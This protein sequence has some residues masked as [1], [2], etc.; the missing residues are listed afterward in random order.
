MSLSL[1]PLPRS[2]SLFVSINTRSIP[3]VGTRPISRRFRKSRCCASSS[4]KSA[5]D[6]SSDDVSRATL[7]WRAVKLPIYS[8]AL[9]PLTVLLQ[10]SSNNIFEFQLLMRCFDLVISNNTDCTR[11]KRDA[12]NENL[13]ITVVEV[14]PSMVKVSIDHSRLFTNFK[15]NL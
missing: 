7:L 1:L 14:C 13:Y 12:I 5:L 10:N 8:V 15:F 6:S 3:P 9:V 4:P 11:W 2:P